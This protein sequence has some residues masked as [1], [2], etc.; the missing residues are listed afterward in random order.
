MG[1][2]AV[3]VV[4]VFTAAAVAMA[5]LVIWHRMQSFDQWARAMGIVREFGERYA[6]PIAK[7][8]QVLEAMTV[9]M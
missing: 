7:L 6:T 3:G 4:V 1:K 5:A 2:V 9:K 8:H